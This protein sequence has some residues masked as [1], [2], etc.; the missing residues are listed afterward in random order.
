MG[1]LK[2]EG[3][4]YFFPDFCILFVDLLMCHWHKIF[5]DTL[6]K[7]PVFQRGT[8]AVAVAPC[9]LQQAARRCR[10]PASLR[11]HLGCLE[12][13]VARLQA[14]TTRH[15]DESETTVLCSDWH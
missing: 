9:P 1:G 14:G 2:I 13:V 8:T 6:T 4:L 11:S 3:L 10:N 5:V 7:F 12:K 15:Q